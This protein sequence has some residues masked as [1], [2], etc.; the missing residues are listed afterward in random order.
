VVRWTLRRNHRQWCLPSVG[1]KWAT[2]VPVV[3]TERTAI[4]QPSTRTAVV[5]STGTAVVPSTGAEV[6]TSTGK[7]LVPSTAA[8]TLDSEDK[9]TMERT[10]I[11]VYA[12]KQILTKILNKNG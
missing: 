7:A 8:V 12:N 2:V 9:S 6:V 5:L 1:S 4:E 10:Y 11:V 3:S